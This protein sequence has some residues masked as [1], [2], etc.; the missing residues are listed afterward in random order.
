MLRGSSTR[1]RDVAHP[2]LQPA[3]EMQSADDPASHDG[4]GEP[5]AEI[6]ER[7]LPADQP[8][9]KPERDLVDHRRGDQEREGDAERHTGADEADE[10]RHGRAGA[11]RRDDAETRRQH[12]A[13][14]FAA[15]RQAARASFP[16]KRS[17][18]PRP[19]RIR[20]CQQ[21]Q[22]FRRVVDEETEGLARRLLRST[23]SNRRPP[24]PRTDELA[25]DD[26]PQSQGDNGPPIHLTVEG[27]APGRGSLIDP[28]LMRHPFRDPA[29]SQARHRQARRPLPEDWGPAVA[30]PLGVTSVD[31][32]A[33]ALERRHMTGHT[34]LAGT[35][36]PHQFADTML[37]PIPHHSEGFEPNRLCECGKNCD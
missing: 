36:V 20:Q 3:F 19:C 30:H 32:E 12:V 13:D 15:S 22:H 23:G 6:G 11:E 24:N 10:Q 21:H 37:A 2:F 9:Q 18:A 28:I 29:G 31:D 1:P 14:A 25:V 26:A 4:D 5:E 34:G 8:E 17:C 16:A 27:R 7:H 33:S 35:E